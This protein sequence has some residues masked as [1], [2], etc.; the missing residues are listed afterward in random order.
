MA[1]PSRWRPQLYWIGS[2]FSN[3]LPTGIG[4]DAVR[5]MLTPAPRGGCKGA[6]RILVGG[7]SGL[8]VM[9]L[10]M[11]A[12]LIL[13]LELGGAGDVNATGG[14]G[15]VG[16][17]ITGTFNGQIT[18]DFAETTGSIALAVGATGGGG[19]GSRGG[20]QTANAGTG[21]QG[22]TI[23]GFAIGGSITSANR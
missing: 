17:T 12:I 2:F 7:L 11:L 9:L 6:A 21:G 1:C 3:F 14:A 19:E 4:G 22:G 18:S 16:G 20:D 13:P 10:S 15:G 23:N 8:L 5:L